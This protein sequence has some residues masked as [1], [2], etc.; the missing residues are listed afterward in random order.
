[1]QNNQEKDL[2]NS[3]DLENSKDLQKKPKKTRKARKK[4]HTFVNP[5][6]TRKK[7]KFW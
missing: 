6:D 5:Y 4:K 7:R 1:V 2:Q 3:K